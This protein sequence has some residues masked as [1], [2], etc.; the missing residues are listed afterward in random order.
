LSLAS[1]PD[2]PA[3]L[4]DFPARTVPANYP[5]SRIHHDRHEAEWFCDK[6]DCRF[7]PPPGA[8]FG[9]CY[10]SGHP[11][12]AF[13]EKFGRL[14]VVPRS[15]VDQHSLASLRLASPVRVA[16]VTDRKILGRWHLSAEL[17]AGDDYDR[18]QL[19]PSDSTK[20]ASPGSGTPPPTM[21]VAA[22]TAWPRSANPD[23]SPTPSS[24]TPM[25]RSHKR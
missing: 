11:L 4:A 8:G 9:T 6:G 5:Y 15:L 24:G 22:C 25:S 23:I 21:F 14:R 20:P 18:S 12:G 19:W 7:D 17:W 1:P 2:N 16:D 10:L 13:V 3:E